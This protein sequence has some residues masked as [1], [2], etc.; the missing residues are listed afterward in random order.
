[1]LFLGVL[2]EWRIFKE[3]A[4]LPTPKGMTDV[5]ACT[6]QVAGVT[7]WMAMNGLRPLGSPGGKGEVILIQGTGGV[8]INGLQIAKASGAEGMSCSDPLI[9]AGLTNSVIITSSSDEKLARA[10][11]LG[12]DHLIN[13]RTTPDWDEEVLRITNGR[14][15]DI[16][17][18]NGGAL[19]TA[20]SF[21]CIR[22]GGLFN[23]IGYV[24]GKVDPPEERL[25]INVQAI[26]KNVTLVGMLN[27]PT[28]RF[29]EMLEFFEKFEIK[30][31]VDRVFAFEDAKVA[32]EYL[33]SG[34]HFG[35]VVIKMSP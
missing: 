4:L 15:A 24:S 29:E 27:G 8:A 35:K 34:S 19:T 9:S 2:C 28:D 12:A 20:K 31:V 17:F 6:L 33:W 32:L 30:P 21:N 1:M 7:A 16:I 11:A 25:N 10:K 18:E 23:A 5:E 3:D 13:Y 14:G 26:R 22:F